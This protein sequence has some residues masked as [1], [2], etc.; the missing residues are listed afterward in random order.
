MV[1]RQLKLSDELDEVY[2]LLNEE[3][4]KVFHHVRVVKE[5]RERYGMGRL[6]GM[7]CEAREQFTGEAIDMLY[8]IIKERKMI[9]PGKLSLLMAQQKQESGK[10]LYPGR[11]S[12]Q[13]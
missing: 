5:V 12:T 10:T 2:R 9:P 4:G 1:N 7:V 6:L 11:P 13:S 8:E 3:K